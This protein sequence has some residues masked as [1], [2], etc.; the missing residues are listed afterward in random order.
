MTHLHRTAALAAVLVFGMS[1]AASAQQACNRKLSDPIYRQFVSSRGTDSTSAT[2]FARQ[3]LRVCTDATIP[4]TK[5]VQDYL[6]EI[7]R[8]HAA[9]LAA[10]ERRQRRAEL[11]D[12]IVQQKNFPEAFAAGTKLLAED[13]L[14]LEVLT[15]LAYAGFLAL[16]TQNRAY[17]TLAIAY[18]ARAI[19]LLDSGRVRE[20][21]Q[22]FASR[23]ETLAWMHFAT[24]TM[25]YDRN[26]KESVKHLYQAT[27]Y[28]T[29][30]RQDAALHYVLASAFEAATY[31][32][33]AKAYRE[34]FGGKPVNEAQKKAKLE[35]DQAMD[36]VIELYAHAVAYAAADDP[37]RAGWL[38]RLTQYYKARHGGKDTGLQAVIDKART[39][40]VAPFTS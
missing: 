9:R 2:T 30:L 11:A 10:E 37:N 7:D 33:L 4:A 24:G 18:A 12:L 14:D 16:Q 38:E 31:I 23:D 27:T 15:N 34:K 6:A 20:T 40:P 26:P 35:V 22:P 36:R 13:S 8:A 17:D 1:A 5:E 25:L 39:T 28:E 19:A 32:P 21:W 29:S 3:Y